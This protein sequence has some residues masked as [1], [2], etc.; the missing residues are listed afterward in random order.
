MPAFSRPLFGRGST[1]AYDYRRRLG[2]FLA[3]RRLA[4]EMTQEELANLLGVVPTSI[5]AIELGRS[6]VAPERCEA[7]AEALGLDK[8]DFGKL[9]FRYSNPWL[10][11]MIFGVEGDPELQKD[12]ANIPERVKPP[13][14]KRRGDART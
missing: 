4:R 10:Y 8:A 1:I 3:E 7:Y 6:T 11:A 13:K 14:P 2:Q 9:M 12:L 5:S